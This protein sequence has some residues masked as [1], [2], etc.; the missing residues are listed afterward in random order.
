[1]LRAVVFR[2]DPQHGTPQRA[3]LAT[4]KATI[5]LLRYRQRLVV[6]F[7]MFKICLTRHLAF[8]MEVASSKRPAPQF[9]ELNVGLES[10]F[11]TRERAYNS[12][13]WS[14]NASPR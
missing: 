11:N 8:L 14:R 10:V 4:A 3:R 7:F 6:Q 2:A 9:A 5:V 13:V 1:M 12:L